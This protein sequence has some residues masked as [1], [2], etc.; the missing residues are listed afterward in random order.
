MRVLHGPAN[1][2]N[3]PWELSRAERELGLKS[4]LVVNYGTWLH[5][6]S[7]RILSKPGDKSFFS[8]IHR[9]LFGLSAPLRYDVLH[10]YF[11]R[12]FML[13]DDLGAKLGERD[14]IVLA[15][16]HL[17]RRLGRRIFM[18]LQGCDIRLAAESNRINAITPCAEGKCPAFSTC[19]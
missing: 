4:D 1:V 13:W 19:V 8:R 14:D 12:T 16:L 10:Y 2:G 3:Q 15:D 9:S 18:T 7:D 17:A 5:Y 6:P 11:G